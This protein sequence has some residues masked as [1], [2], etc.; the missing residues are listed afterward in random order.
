VNGRVLRRVNI[1]NIAVIILVV[2]VRDYGCHG[3]SCETWRL[4][5][6]T[7]ESGASKGFRALTGHIISYWNHTRSMR[8]TV[9]GVWC[10]GGSREI[11]GDGRIC[12]HKEG[13]A[14]TSIGTRLALRPRLECGSFLP[15]QNPNPVRGGAPLRKT[16]C[17][18]NRCLPKRHGKS[19]SL[20]NSQSFHHGC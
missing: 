12:N 9:M 5:D 4:L 8:Q 1:V 16:G 18:P 2:A 19:I 20:R 14:C 7:W 13:R 17:P 10:P 15:I 6:T 3:C 11:G